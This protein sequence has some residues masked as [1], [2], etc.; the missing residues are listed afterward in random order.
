MPF[1]RHDRV[2]LSRS[3]SGPA[4]AARLYRPYR[5]L[6][7]A[8][9]LERARADR[10]ALAG[11][12]EAERLV[13]PGGVRVRVV[14]PQPEVVRAV[15]RGPGDRLVHQSAPHAEASAAGVDPRRG[16]V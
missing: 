2:K 10:L 13:E 7:A 12:D 3:T 1:A 15:R 11:R 16:E 6:E 14:H 5:P 9:A 8:L 4:P